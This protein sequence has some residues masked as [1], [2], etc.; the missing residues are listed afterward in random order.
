MA[1]LFEEMQTEKTYQYLLKYYPGIV[2]II[3]SS[4]HRI[5]DVNE[6]AV[7]FYGYSHEEFYNKNID[8]INI[9]TM[10]ELKREMAMAKRQ[11]RTFFNVVHKLKDGTLKNVQVFSYPIEVGGNTLMFTVMLEEKGKNDVE[12]NSFLK[13]SSDA[14]CVVDN[15]DIFE[16]SIIFSNHVFSRIVNIESSRLSQL[17]LKDIF[18]EIHI[19][20]NGVNNTDSLVREC[21]INN[22]NRQ[23]VQIS[24]VHVRNS[25]TVY[26]VVGVK[27]LEYEALMPLISP[28][29]VVEKLL[30]DCCYKKG[31]LIGIELY[32][33]KNKGTDKVGYL[34]YVYSTI[35]R[36]L[37]E[38]NI[39]F[40][41]EKVGFSILLF[42]PNEIQDISNVLNDFIT[43][44]ENERVCL[45]LK[46]EFGFRLGVS[47]RTNLVNIL[48]ESL[49]HTFNAFFEGQYNQVIYSEYHTSD[50]K[51]IILQRDIDKAIANNEF[52][53]FGQ[54]IVDIE[55]KRVEGI[56]LLIRWEHPIYG[57]LSPNDFI[58]YAV[59]SLQIKE[60]DI[61][62]VKKSIQLLREYKSQLKDIILHVNIS[63]LS[64]AN[65]EL[66][67]CFEDVHD[68]EILK[69]IVLEVTE[70]V[71]EEVITNA[72]RGLKRL[73]IPFAVDDFG[74]GY[75]SYDRLREVGAEILKID[76]ILIDN[77]TNDQDTITILSSII[78]MCKSLNIIP[79]AE[80]VETVEQLKILINCH[81]QRVQ[82][83]YFSIPIKFDTIIKQVDSINQHA[84]TSISDLRQYFDEKSMKYNEIN[85]FK[86]N[87]KSYL[88]IDTMNLINTLIIGIVILD[89][90]FRILDINAV[91]ESYLSNGNESILGK[92][93]FKLID[94]QS[95]ELYQLLLNA[96]VGYTQETVIKHRVFKD[97]SKII[98]LR[99]NVAVSRED[100]HKNKIFLCMVEN[101]SE[102]MELKRN[103]DR[104]NDALERSP[105]VVFMTDLDGKFEYVNEA[106]IK[107]TGYAKSEIIGQSTKILST[108]D[109]DRSY[110]TELWEKITHK[111]IWSGVFKDKRKDGS[112]YWC[113]QNIYPIIESE[114]IKGFIGIQEELSKEIKLQEVYNSVE[115]IHVEINNLVESFEVLGEKENALDFI[116]EKIEMLSDKIDKTKKIFES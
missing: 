39:K 12:L 32:S 69:H 21:Y 68:N 10:E 55:S 110:Y 60:I 66:L 30:K 13:Y 74:T 91:A 85:S 103:S 11:K 78:N 79:V 16:G 88:N 6:K 5:I 19:N 56:E 44:I 106:F 111:E 54:G 64:L 42:T 41:V 67:S 9:Y 77:I 4:Q 101:V 3:D 65:T 2:F 89:E 76:K 87:D 37:E 62:V 61:W 105:S 52:V 45:E 22:E 20:E 14:I 71:T 108:K 81:C 31:Y 38:N 75:S 17:K 84:M 80:G 94:D 113:R 26:T 96:Y 70:E 109:G 8:E 100:G 35:C 15:A 48:R 28:K 104:N 102:N 23:K 83:Y 59:R 86:Q 116:K 36:L 46:N 97:N 114:R 27:V 33:V 7:E 90:D 112:Y 63:T 72:F 98:Y 47:D 107:L 93:I 99:W 57:L 95:E 51:E 92:S 58:P 82:G 40:S 18:K 43:I 53:L 34:N 25:G 50:K 115:D 29:N 1:N 24:T 49:M 73:G